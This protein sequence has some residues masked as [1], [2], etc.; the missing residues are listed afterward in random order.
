MNSIAAYML[1]ETFNFRALGTPLFHGLEQY[2]GPYYSFLLT[3]WNAAVIYMIL[4]YMHKKRIY[5]KV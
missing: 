2:I 4:L 5:L 3:T 1:A